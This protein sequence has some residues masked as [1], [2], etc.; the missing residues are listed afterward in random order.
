VFN[1]VLTA[2]CFSAALTDLAVEV[3]PATLLGHG[4]AFG[5]DL[6]E[7]L[8]PILAANGGSAPAGGL[9]ARLGARLLAG[10]WDGWR[11]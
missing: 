4:P 2:S 7:V 9:C 10:N 5:A 11:G 6:A 1:A 8:G 3:Q